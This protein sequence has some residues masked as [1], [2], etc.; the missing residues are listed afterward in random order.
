MTEAY[1]PPWW[2]DEDRAR[3]KAWFDS[4]QIC[5]HCCQRVPTTEVEQGLHRHLAVMD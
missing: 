5:D 4:T 2:T 1:G 3:V